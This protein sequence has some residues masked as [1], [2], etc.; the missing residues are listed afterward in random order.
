M[1]CFLGISSFNN[2]NYISLLVVVNMVLPPPFSSDHVLYSCLL[3]PSFF[4]L[5]HELKHSIR[6]RLWDGTGSLCGQFGQDVDL[7]FSELEL[8]M[9][10]T[11]FFP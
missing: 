2:I 6:W 8:G 10:L 3:F 11:L 1:Y 9:Q 4:F 7:R 5:S